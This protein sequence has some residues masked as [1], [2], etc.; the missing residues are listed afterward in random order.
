MGKK[1]KR[2]RHNFNIFS[3]KLYLLI[4]QCSFDSFSLARNKV[5]KQRGNDFLLLTSQSFISVTTA[6]VCRECYNLILWKYLLSTCLSIEFFSKLIIIV[7]VQTCFHDFTSFILAPFV[8][9]VS[10]LGAL[11]KYFCLI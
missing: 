3:A 6:A 7:M 10:F 5:K 2:T 8:V 4:F 11:I 1:F 9:I